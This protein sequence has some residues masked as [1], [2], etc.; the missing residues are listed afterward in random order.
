MRAEPAR[1]FVDDLRNFRAAEPDSGQRVAQGF[2]ALKR[3]HK[4]IGL[5]DGLL[6]HRLNRRKRH[7][8]RDRIGR[9]RVGHQ[10][11]LGDVQRRN[12]QEKREVDPPSPMG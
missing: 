11:A 10:A 4:R 8:A 5:D 12:S 2:A 7:G 3:K 6:D 1:E 9:L